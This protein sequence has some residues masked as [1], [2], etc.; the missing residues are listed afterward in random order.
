[1]SRLG[2]SVSWNREFV[3]GQEGAQEEFG[4]EDKKENRNGAEKTKSRDQE[5]I[6]GAQEGG[7][8]G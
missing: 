8:A 6:L 1:M 3:D 4:F 5:K 2:W 7:A